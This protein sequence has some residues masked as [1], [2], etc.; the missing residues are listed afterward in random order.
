MRK[1][2]GFR[3]TGIGIG[4]S[5]L[6]TTMLSNGLK[7]ALDFPMARYS[8]SPGFPSWVQMSVIHNAPDGNIN[9]KC[10]LPVL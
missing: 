9:N 7:V 2:T 5:F 10:V 3:A 8:C 6:K 4:I 1:L